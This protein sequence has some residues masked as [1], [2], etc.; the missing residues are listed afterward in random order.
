MITEQEFQNQYVLP[1]GS[2]YHIYYA[3]KGFIVWR[4]G[5]GCNTELLHIKTFEKGKGYGRELVYQMLDTIDPYYSVFGFTRVGNKEAKKFYGALGFELQKVNGIY[6]DG[7]SVLFWQSYEEL[8]KQRT[9]YERK[10]Y[11]YGEAIP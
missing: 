4:K 11:N 5:T 6:K 2:V 3:V 8:K 9:D 7:S 10:S 1:F